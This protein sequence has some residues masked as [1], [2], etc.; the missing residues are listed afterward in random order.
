MMQISLQNSRGKVVFSG[1]PWNPP[2]AP[3]GVKVPWSLKCKE[4]F[5]RLNPGMNKVNV[6]GEYLTELR[7]ADDVTLTTTSVKDTEV[8]LKC[9]N[10]ESKKNGMKIHKGKKQSL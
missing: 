8:Q 9:L 7:F 10:S 4:V 5:K 1:G 3:T 2:W 6:D